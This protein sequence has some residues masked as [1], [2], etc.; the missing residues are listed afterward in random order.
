MG[1]KDRGSERG[2]GSSKEIFIGERVLLEISLGLL[3]ASLDLRSVD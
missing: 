2:G 1:R 3:D